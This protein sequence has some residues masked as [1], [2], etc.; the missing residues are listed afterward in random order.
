MRAL[1]GAGGNE[2]AGCIA[3]AFQL[4]RVEQRQNPSMTDLAERLLKLIDEDVEFDGLPVRTHEEPAV[5]LMNL[6]KVKG[7]EA[8]VVFLANPTG[9][10]D[11]PV[12]L[13]IDRSGERVRGY[14]AVY[15]ESSGYGTPPLLACPA[16]W[17]IY[18]AEEQRFGDAERNRLLYV[19]ATRISATS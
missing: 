12:S 1:A 9:K 14:L 4:L 8:A 17:E 15:G 13:H 18:S 19:A 3:K 10:W 2:R 16:N 6:H 7:L 11:P 5:R